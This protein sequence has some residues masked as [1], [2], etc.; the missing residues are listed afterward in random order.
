MGS[1]V[2]GLVEGALGAFTGAEKGRR[3]ERAG[4]KAEQQ[5][6]EANQYIR[7]ELPYQDQIGRGQQAEGMIAGLLGVGGD[8]SAG[9]AGLDS[10]LDSS[11]Y[12]FVLDQGRDGIAAN[13]AA[14]GKLNSGARDK[15]AIGFGQNIAQQYLTDYLGQLGGISGIG[16]QA[17]GTLAQGAL[18]AAGG[19]ADALFKA[20][21]GS[22]EARDQGYSD[23]AAGFGFGHNELFG[24]DGMFPNYGM[25]SNPFGGGGGAASGGADGH[26]AM[27]ANPLNFFG[28]G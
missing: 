11:G 23:A 9:Q 8:P 28:G 7:E 22:A 20:E 12:N 16:N 2:G 13:M 21:T 5:Y 27:D 1:I 26:M 15:A 4:R 6:D 25:G 18:G 14:S 17:A 19:T 24:S 10:F 3:Y